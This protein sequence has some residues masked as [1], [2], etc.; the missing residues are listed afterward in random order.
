M[1]DVIDF[2]TDGRVADRKTVLDGSALGRP[3]RKTTRYRLLERQ[4]FFAV[5]SLNFYQKLGLCSCVGS[6]ESLSYGIHLHV[7]F[8][9]Q[10]HGVSVTMALQYNLR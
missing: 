4:P 9:C 7:C 3:E 8:L 6:L 2:G 1:K 10:Y 5:W